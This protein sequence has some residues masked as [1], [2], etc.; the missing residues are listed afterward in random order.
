MRLEKCTE[1]Y[2]FVMSDFRLD[3]R[4]HV[5]FRILEEETGEERTAFVPWDQLPIEPPD[6]YG[7]V[8]LANSLCRAGLYGVRE[9]NFVVDLCTPTNYELW[10]LEEGDNRP[11]ASIHRNKDLA[12]FVTRYTCFQE[13]LPLLP[14]EQL[15]TKCPA[16]R[17]SAAK[18]QHLVMDHIQF[19]IESALDF[20]GAAEFLYAP[21]DPPI[22]SVTMLV[23]RWTGHLCA[24]EA[25]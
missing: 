18:N 7:D 19:I 10:G 2:F 24:D 21:D 8:V 16:T 9:H 13:S 25:E 11:L 22:V 4:S 5:A 17:P 6:G 14:L 3:G 23:R 12:D 1:R 20:A 15:S